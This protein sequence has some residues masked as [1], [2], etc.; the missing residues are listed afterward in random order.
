[1]KRV[2]VESLQWVAMLTNAH[3]RDNTGVI[4]V[5]NSS[6]I[7]DIPTL[8]HDV[9]CTVVELSPCDAQGKGSTFFLVDRVEFVRGATSALRRRHALLWSVCASLFV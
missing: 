4:F 1:M 9:R 5:V 2:S 7:A 3:V 8:N 6:D